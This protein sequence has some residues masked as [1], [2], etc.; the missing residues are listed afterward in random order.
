MTF[1]FAAANFG[2]TAGAVTAGLLAFF[3]M[4]AA[5]C[6][7]M[8][9]PW[10]RDN[11]VAPQLEQL[12][13]KDLGPQLDRIE[14]TAVTTNKLVVYHLGANGSTIPLRDR[15]LTLE[16]TVGNIKEDVT[17]LKVATSA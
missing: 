14:S 13:S 6:K 3:T 17:E 9:V 4:L 10:L 12:R 15:V 5:F 1:A 16:S 8:V 11:V 2:M 7:L